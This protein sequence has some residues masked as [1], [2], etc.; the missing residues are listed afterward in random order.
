MLFN[1]MK[2]KYSKKKLYIDVS[3]INV[4]H[5][6]GGNQAA[7]NILDCIIKNKKITKYFDII[8]LGRTKF[9]ENKTFPKYI[10]KI[11]LPN[12]YLLN[13]MIRWFI[14]IFLSDK[15]YKQ[16]YF[17]TNIYSPLI[18]LNFKVI[19][20]FY[21]NQWKYFPENYS[22]IKI[23]WIKTNI[24]LSN[25]IADKILC[26]SNF[27]KKEFLNNK[28]NL[29]KIYVPIKKIKYST[30]PKYITKK[31]ALSISSM[32]PHKN[33]KVLEQ[34]YLNNNIKNLPA[35]LVIAGV[36]GKKKILQ[37]NKIK[38]TYLGKVSEGEK[39]WLLKNCEFYISSTLYEGLGMTLI[40]AYLKNKKIICSD[41]E[42]FREILG[43]YPIYVKQPL[44]NK[45]WIK[46]LNQIVKNKNKRQRS[47]KI[48]NK[49]KPFN[50][51]NQYFSLFQ[52]ITE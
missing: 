38:I 12:I 39:N 5:S 45:Y 37:K 35:N 48:L 41:L 32:L 2:H 18:K 44:K 19:N 15:K 47:L 46:N 24:F 4:V 40:E 20:I 17:C 7:T 3:W 34:V 33:L 22:F 27:T 25:H 13:F 26:I 14:L 36:G 51:S 29:L 50:I 23:L 1:K 8:L 30:Q 43:S 42:V 16:I 11:N 10:K 52:S 49:F 6:G 9:F 21:D 28:N 31:F